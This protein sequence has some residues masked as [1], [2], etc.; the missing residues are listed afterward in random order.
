MKLSITAAATVLFFGALV[1]SCGKGQ[2]I[3][4]DTA[5]FEAAIAA[6]LSAHSMDMQVAECRSLHVEGDEATAVC[7][8]E[9]KAGLYG[10][11]GVTWTWQFRRRPDGTWE[12]ADLDR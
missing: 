3:S 9:D 5:P 1:T 8:M 10:G 12:V 4:A 7:K 2:A 11:V 6:Y